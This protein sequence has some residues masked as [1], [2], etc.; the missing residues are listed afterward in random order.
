MAAGAIR[1]TRLDSG[2]TI[3]TEA[4]ADTRSV[5]A[6]FWVG[7][8]SRD[9]D[10]T[11]AGAS[12]FLEHLLFKGTARRSA[13]SIA[14]A[15]D[16]V[17]GDMNAFTTKEYTVFY[18]R[19]LADALPMGLDILCD[20]MW[21]PA[22]HPDD[23]EAERQVIIEEILMRNDEPA[24]LVHDLFGEAMYP[25]H[26]L[27]RDV[28][29]TEDSI[30]AM[31]RDAIE[32]FF[33][34]HYRPANMVLAAAGQVDHD[35][36]VDTVERRTRGRDGGGRPDR[37]P[38]ACPP[39]PRTVIDRPTEQTHLVV[40]ARA[41]DRH[42][43]DRFALTLFNHSL[44]GGM[45]SRLFQAI[46]EERGLAY[47]V[48]S[49]RS[50]Y[51]DA[52]HQAIYAGSAPSRAPQVLDLIHGELDALVADGVSERELTVAKGHLRGETALALEDS[53]ARMSRIGRG[54]LLHGSVLEVEDLL[55]R[56]EAVTLDEVHDVA[57]RTW[58]GS[59]V[60]AVVGPEPG[61]PAL[62]AARPPVPK[63]PMKEAG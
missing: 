28:L 55:D 29:G 22:F 32:S 42:R 53:A 58:D 63:L 47:S 45:S 16:S 27:G 10:V 18:V 46:R 35:A 3:V 8:G 19:V 51:D 15:I 7:T 17:G 33:Q 9:E 26:P 60:E 62:P 11:S 2:L 4:M 40:G 52:G 21:T 30:E 14:E 5:S 59:R 43:D 41:G 56:F 57:R 49:Y 23:V 20:I 36:F 39:A 6:G 44:G 31:S 13:R 48:Y 50:S 38:P 25:G 34:T 61:Q 12:H 54:Q 37:K 24:D 1:S